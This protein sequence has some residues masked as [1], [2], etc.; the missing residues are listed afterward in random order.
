M[1]RVLEP[2]VMDTPEEAIE[3]D[4][5]DFTEVNAA[6][7]QHAIELGPKSGIVLDAGTG[8]ARI[9]IAICQQCPQW[10]IIGIDLAQT[11]LF[12]GSKN[13][14]QAGLQKQISL[15]IVDSKLLPYPDEH[16]EMVI[17]NSL[18]HHLPDPLPFF[19][20]AKRVL[21]PNGAILIRDLIRP[22]DEATMN[23]MVDSIGT[24]Y[25][26]HQKKLFRD[27]LH[28][29]FTLDEVNELMQ[30]AGLNGV[31]VYQSSDRHWT[32]QRKYTA[33]G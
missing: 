29:A 26:E 31:Q 33:A 1:Q 24:E 17:S 22:A 4:A 11:M 7:A 15:E 19:L 23:A 18:V 25:D 27:S 5:M 2:E 6:F 12:V 32:A 16:F 21:K 13:V 20:E 30:K 8:T 9:P 3:Y 14:Q 10:Q 28:A